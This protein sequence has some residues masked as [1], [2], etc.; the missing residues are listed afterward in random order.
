MQ[1]N[2]KFNSIQFICVLTLTVPNFKLYI[3]ERMQNNIRTYKKLPDKD[4]QLFT[5]ELYAVERLSV[6]KGQGTTEV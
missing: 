3:Y 6:A 4:E 5:A 1:K 2:N